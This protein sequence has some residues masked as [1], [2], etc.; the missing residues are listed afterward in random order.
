[1]EVILL[2][3]RADP[4]GNR[5]GLQDVNRD[6]SPEKHALRGGDCEGR[7]GATR[8]C[9]RQEIGERMTEKTTFEQ[10]LERGKGVSSTDKQGGGAF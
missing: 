10:R 4:D 9:P 2:W 1:M 7:A 8:L 3:G 5:Y 6:Q